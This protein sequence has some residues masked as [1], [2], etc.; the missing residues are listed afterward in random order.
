MMFS[1]RAALAAPLLLLASAALA[2]QPVT[3]QAVTQPGPALPQFTRV[4]V[5]MLREGLPQRSGGR[6]QVTLAS[7]PERN[8]NGPEIIRLVR[9]GQVDIGAVPLNTV[10]GDVPL[11]DVADLAGLNP[12]LPQARRIARAILPDVNRELERF[13]VRIVAMY[14]FPAQVFFCREPVTSLADLRGRRVR[15]PGGSQNDFIQAI[16]AQPVAIGFP[17]VYAALERGVVDCAVTGT[18]TGNGARWYEVTR[19]MYVLPVQWGVAAY[20]VNLNWW[21]RLDPAVRDFLQATMTE[22]Q[23]QQWALGLELTD[24]GIACNGGQRDG[25]RIGRVVENRPMVITRASQADVET[26]RSSLTNVVLPAWV[27]RCGARCG[28]TYNRLVAPITGVRYE[29]R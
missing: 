22:V 17:E 8:L 29:A 6:I 19:H 9:S 5:P 11:L 2:Q 12:D 10:S 27:R 25:C 24:D 20:G 23:E 3:I 16:G 26:L 13:G 4:D 18:A 1:R 15:T 7:W 21:N 28:E 14:P